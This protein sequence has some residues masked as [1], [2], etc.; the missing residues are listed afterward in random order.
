ME[1]HYRA[2]SH[3]PTGEGGILLQRHGKKVW[4][5]VWQKVQSKRYYK[6]WQGKPYWSLRKFYVGEVWKCWSD[7][8]SNA[9]TPVT[10]EPT[11]WGDI[12]NKAWRYPD[13]ERVRSPY[14]DSNLYRW[15]TLNAR[16]G[17]GLCNQLI[18][19][20]LGIKCPRQRDR[21]S[22]KTE[23]SHV[24]QSRMLASSVRNNIKPSYKF[25]TGDGWFQGSDWISLYLQGERCRATVVECNRMNPVVR[26]DW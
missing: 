18:L 14:T 8:D 15:R 26:A 4:K 3:C 5:N 1:R 9:A 11:R 6:E 20:S 17:S 22:H 13:R 25:E 19:F 7:F 16:R 10:K 12:P 24:A 21:N 2:G 23:C